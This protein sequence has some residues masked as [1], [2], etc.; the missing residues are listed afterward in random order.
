[1]KV[2][3]LINYA[4]QG[5]TEKYVLQLVDGM[6]NAGVKCYFAYNN[7]GLLAEQMAQKKISTFQFEMKSPYDLKAAKTLAR[8]CRQNKI[9]IIHAQHPRENYIAVLSRLYYRKVRVV[10]TSHILVQNNLAWKITNRLIGKRCDKA[11]T[12]CNAGKELLI[13]NGFDA[14]KTQVIFN[15]IPIQDS[16]PESTLRKELGLSGDTFVIAALTRYSAE[17]GVEFLVDT[18]SELKQKTKRKFVLLIAGKGENYD[19]I[20]QRITDLGLGDVIIRLGYRQDTSNILQACDLFINLSQTEALSFAIIEALSHA[21]PCVVT[22]VGGTGDIV[23]NS[24]CCGIAVEYLDVFGA[25]NAVIT[26]MENTELYKKYSEGAIKNAKENF[27]EKVM[28]SKTLDIYN[29]LTAKKKG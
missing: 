25:S 7:H 20:G 26:L 17:K 18:I 12:V 23:N 5:G 2:L 3:Y 8:I 27:D 22:N 29:T 9:D 28:L 10:Y 1:M 21:K 14:K 6:T 4:G 16:F 19:A 24:S 11:I 15:G 13:K